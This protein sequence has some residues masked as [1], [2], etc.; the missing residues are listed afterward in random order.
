MLQPSHLSSGNEEGFYFPSVI[1][2]SVI[3]AGNKGDFSLRYP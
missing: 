2:I 1:V 3:S